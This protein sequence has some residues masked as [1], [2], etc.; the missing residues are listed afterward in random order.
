M[1]QQEKVKP[2]KDFRAGNF[3]ASVWRNEVQKDGQ[4]VVR[5]TGTAA[6][7]GKAPEAPEATSGSGC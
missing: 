7:A 3:Q 5:Y 4:T 6:A 2:I 1:S